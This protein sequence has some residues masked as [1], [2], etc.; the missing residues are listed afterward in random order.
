[1]AV[2]KVQ[3]ADGTT[4]IDITDTTASAADVAEGVV[5]YTAD[6]V[7]TVGTMKEND[8]ELL[9]SKTWLGTTIRCWRNGR[10]V[11]LQWSGVES[12]T[13]TAGSKS[14][15]LSIPA[16]WRPPN[17][18]EAIFTDQNNRRFI[19]LAD[20]SGNAGLSYQLDAVSSATNVYGTLTWAAK[21]E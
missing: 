13:S 5:F 3:L 10:T 2:N 20:T 9:S 14:Q 6:G 4:L 15:F 19:F 8:Y 1:M 12:G 17:R 18:V 21:G 16:K 11:T 7:R